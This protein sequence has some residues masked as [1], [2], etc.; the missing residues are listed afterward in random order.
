MSSD[1]WSLRELQIIML[2]RLRHLSQYSVNIQRTV[3]RRLQRHQAIKPLTITS[4][5]FV[6]TTPLPIP[7]DKQQTNKNESLSTEPKK[8]GKPEDLHPSQLNY[9][10]PT[11]I[12]EKEKGK[13]CNRHGMRGKGFFK[14]KD[15]SSICWEEWTLAEIAKNGTG[16]LTVNLP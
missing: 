15:F 14:G 12:T 2:C 4:S 8:P 1:C 13:L 7:S 16:Q 5:Q 9:L 3:S 6:A 10:L 11:S